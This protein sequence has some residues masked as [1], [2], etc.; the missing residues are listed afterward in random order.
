MS[1]AHFHR[2]EVARLVERHGHVVVVDSS[3]QDVDVDRVSGADWKGDVLLAVRPGLVKG[4]QLDLWK[5]YLEQPG[6]SRC[7]LG[8]TNPRSRCRDGPNPLQATPTSLLT[9]LVWNAPEA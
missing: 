3:L 1:L 2:G 7:E 9:K 6:P 4:P 8:W 5:N